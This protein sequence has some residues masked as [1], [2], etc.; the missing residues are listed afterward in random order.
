MNRHQRGKCRGFN[1]SSAW[2]CDAPLLFPEAYPFKEEID[3]VLSCERGNA[4]VFLKSFK[5]NSNQPELKFGRVI[6]ARQRFLIG[7][8][9][10]T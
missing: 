6:L 10:S 8:Q 3:V 9:V 2:S 1:F 7:H 4:A 5:R